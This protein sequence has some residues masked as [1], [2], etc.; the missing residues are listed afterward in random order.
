MVSVCPIIV[1]SKLEHVIS[2][3]ERA[4]SCARLAF[5]V[6]DEHSVRSLSLEGDHTF[7]QWLLV[8]LRNPCQVLS[9][10]LHHDYVVL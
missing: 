2:V 8:F 7:P 9:W 1:D 4:L 10:W 3:W 6:T 5:F